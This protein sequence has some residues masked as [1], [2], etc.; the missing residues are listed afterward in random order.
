MQR[1]NQ[2]WFKQDSTSPLLTQQAFHFPQLKMYKEERK[3]L[4][5]TSNLDKTWC[6]SPRSSAHCGEA[7]C[8][9]NCT[10]LCRTLV[11]G[12]VHAKPTSGLALWINLELAFGVHP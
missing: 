10:Y 8:C 3:V 5:G 7:R 2:N 4:K 6:L 9:S 11:G 12:W 1:G